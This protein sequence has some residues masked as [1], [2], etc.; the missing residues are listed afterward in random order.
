MALPKWHE[1]MWHVLAALSCQEIA[2]KS[3]L[4]RYVAEQFGLT[5]EE[6]AE[7]LKSGKTKLYDRVYWATK[8]LRIAGFVRSGSKRGTYYI[9]D[10]GSAFL[11]RHESPFSD[12]AL[13]EESPEVAAWVQESRKR[14][15]GVDGSQAMLESDDSTPLETMENA[16]SKL[17]ETLCDDLLQ[18]LC[19]Q[20]PYV[21]EHIVGELLQK[22]GYGS[23]D[24]DSLKVT[25][26]SGDGGIDGFVREDRL[27]FDVVAYQAK[28]WKP[29]A[30]IGTDI[31]D[32]FVGACSKLGVEKSVFITTA[33]FS[34]GAEEYPRSMKHGRLVLI[35]GRHLV[36]LMVEHGIGVSTV[37]TFEIKEIDSDFFESE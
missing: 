8:Y 1:C 4:D 25:R 33:K 11:G 7:R 23:A 18:R 37:A 14:R 5:D 20:D 16:F 15:T 32:Q 26:K 35:D 9:T 12:Q 21:F 22:M 27:G 28:R 10:S 2:T 6:R 30:T 17:N 19:Q 13:I 36:K 29:D 34:K 3:E 24:E 31:V